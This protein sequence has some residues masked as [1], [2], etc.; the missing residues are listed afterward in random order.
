M[1]VPFPDF[2][3]AIRRKPVTK[4][5]LLVEQKKSRS[6]SKSRTRVAVRGSSLNEAIDELKALAAR[7]STGG[8]KLKVVCS[9]VGRKGRPPLRTLFVRMQHAESDPANAPVILSALPSVCGPTVYQAEAWIFSSL[10][11]LCST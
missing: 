5:R 7:L 10:I 1:A 6:T 4:V 9:D 8:W 3:E 11:T 2:I